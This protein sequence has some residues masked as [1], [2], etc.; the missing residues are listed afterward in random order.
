MHLSVE[1]EEIRCLSRKSNQELA[2]Q[3]TIH[4]FPRAGPASPRP[5]FSWPPGLA[6]LVPCRPWWEID[7]LC[8]F[9]PGRWISRSQRYLGRVF[10]PLPSSSGPLFLTLPSLLKRKI[11]SGENKPQVCLHVD[12][13]NGKLREESPGDLGS[14]HHPREQGRFMLRTRMWT[15]QWIILLCQGK[16]DWGG[17][18]CP[19]G[20]TWAWPQSWRL[21]PGEAVLPLI[22]VTAQLSRADDSSRLSCIRRA[23]I[24]WALFKDSIFLALTHMTL[25]NPRTLWPS[26]LQGWVNWG[27][28]RLTSP[29]WH[30][31][32][33][34]KARHE[35]RWCQICLFP[36]KPYWL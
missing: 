27:T 36:I 11:A 15:Y 25:P 5:A 12:N 4:P 13:I 9:P 30:S 28:K 24:H 7:G 17:N 18:V 2:S 1:E 32:E 26:P 16:L 23:N 31:Q 29:R 34:A 10:L 8:I 3:V 21:A 20:R 14:C 35:P 6:G 22:L 19:R 33:V